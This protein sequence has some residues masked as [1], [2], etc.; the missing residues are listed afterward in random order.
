MDKVDWFALIPI[1]AGVYMY[2][3][4]IG[5]L[6]KNPKEP[7]RMELWRR[8]FGGMMKVLSPLMV[9]IGFLQFFRVL[10]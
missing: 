9:V 4:A 7:E 2:F 8:K 1:F 5:V 10:G 6:P 3:V